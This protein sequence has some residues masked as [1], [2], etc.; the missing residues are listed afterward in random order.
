[1]KKTIFFSTLLCL[2]YL[3]AGDAVKD[4]DASNFDT[5][6]D[7]SKN[8]FVEFFAPWCGHC[9]H[10]APEYEQAGLAFAN[11]K[12]TIIAKVDADKHKD[13][14]SRF[15]V[16]GYPT[17]KFFP[18][19]TPS[20]KEPED[21]SGGRTADDIINFINGKTGSNARQ[22]K[23]ASAVTILTDENFEKIVNDPNKNVLVEFYAPWCGHCKHLAPEYEKVA[24]TFKNEPECI[25]ANIDADNY[26]DISQKHGVSGY[27][28]IKFFPK[29]S[30]SGDKYEGGR[31]PQD[32]INFLN[33]KCGTFRKLGGS[34]NEKAGR[35]DKLDELATKFI[36]AGKREKETLI[37]D[38]E[39]IVNGLSEKVKKIADY[40]VKAMK[41]GDEF[42]TKEK[43]R[44]AKML[45]GSIAADK[46]DEFTIKL[47]ILS[48]FKN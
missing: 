38:A 14:A 33:D 40:Y 43:E 3:I 10:L 17:L 9:K 27:P 32:F 39:K 1:M 28:T 4:L 20:N 42:I 29:N 36:A 22:A 31:E 5:V 34:L 44:L 47:N 30:K 7:G 18:K 24:A 48:S 13:L 21:Y 2:F 46:L 16:R 8:V 15:G 19:G 26:K 6:V 23:P 25:V 37:N 45:S 12:E 11:S 41:K 35:V